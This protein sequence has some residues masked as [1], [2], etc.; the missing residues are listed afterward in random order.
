VVPKKDFS[1]VPEVDSAVI[2]LD[3]KTLP[4]PSSPIDAEQYYKT[5]RGIFAQ[6]RKTLLNNIMAMG[7]GKS[8]DKR[9]IAVARLKKCG[10]DPAA[11]PQDLNIAH[12][13]AI[14]SAMTEE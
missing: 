5:V 4:A 9:E 10:V 11:R 3:T 1:P 7:D 13:I 14:A 6:P 2:V 8:A 12:I